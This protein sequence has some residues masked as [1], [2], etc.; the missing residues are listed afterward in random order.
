MTVTNLIALDW[1]TIKGRGRAAV[2]RL[3]EGATI[4]DVRRLPGKK[5]VIDGSLYT[6]VGAEAHCLPP[7][8]GAN[9]CALL[10]KEGT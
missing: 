1:F 7:H 10:V 9:T 8:A 5:V 6:V 3:P 2:V 4:A